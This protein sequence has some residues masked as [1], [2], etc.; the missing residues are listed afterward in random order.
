MRI[1]FAILFLSLLVLP[2]FVFSQNEIKK[3]EFLPPTE[4][5]DVK[6]FISQNI[7]QSYDSLRFRQSLGKL[8]KQFHDKGFYEATIDSVRSKIFSI[9]KQTEIYVYFF[10]G[11]MYFVK[12]VNV[13]GMSPQ[14][15]SD[16]NP[17]IYF[18]KDKPFNPDGF[19]NYIKRILDYYQNNGYP[20]A[21]IKIDTLKI[22]TENNEVNSKKNKTERKYFS[23]DIGVQLN[24]LVS[25]D[26]VIITGNTKQ[27]HH[28]ILR[29]SGIKEGE[30]YNEKKIRAVPQVLNNSVY[31][32][33]VS[34]VETK[35]IE[36]KSENNPASKI[37]AVITLKVDDEKS[38]SFDGIAGIQP[39][40]ATKKTE[41]IGNVNLKLTNP[42]GGGKTFSFSF[43]KLQAS[44][45]KLHVSYFDPYLMD[46]VRLNL[47]F[48]LYKQDTN[49]IQREWLIKIH[50]PLNIYSSMFAY[51]NPKSSR[52]LSTKAYENSLAP[53]LLDSKTKLYGLGFKFEK[54]D[55]RYNPTRGWDLE[56]SAGAGTKQIIKNPNLLASVYGNL[57]LKSLQLETNGYAKKYFPTFKRQAL[58]L[59]FQYGV[60]NNSELRENDLYRIGGFRNLRGFDEEQFQA[61]GFA[62]AKFEYHYLLEE[63]SFIYVFSDLAYFEKTILTFNEYSASAGIGIGLNYE[64]KIGVMGVSYALGAYRDRVF[65]LNSSK[66]H[67]G[68]VSRF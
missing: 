9:E 52:L 25:I 49:F 58:M 68:F 45:Q 54:L 6:K 57:K 59:G 22:E 42:I 43:D 64:T 39:N 14:T 47:D 29:A 4:N 36:R 46:I 67:V 30:I 2:S 8:L 11:A 31:F 16:F 12:D 61:N 56:L 34:I 53:P 17:K 13:S 60:L 20:F 41:I 24:E 26:S 5:P 10:H 27:K 51:Y 7:N 38:S 62:V 1:L 37:G 35:F 63:N 65:Q 66:I 48:N 32:Q 33:N 40:A 18:K 21:K 55:N 23:F 28:F 3:I 19:N 44:S 50:Y 15:L